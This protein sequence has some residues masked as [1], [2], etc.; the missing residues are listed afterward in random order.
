MARQCDASRVG[1]SELAL[2]GRLAGGK[3]A[4]GG[5][6]EAGLGEARETRFGWEKVWGWDNNWQACE[7]L[8]LL[9]RYSSVRCLPSRLSSSRV[10]AFT[11]FVSPAFLR[12]PSEGRDP[13]VVSLVAVG[14]RSHCRSGAGR[15]SSHRFWIHE[16]GLWSAQ[17]APA[18]VPGSLA[19]LGDGDDPARSVWAARFLGAV[20]TVVL[21]GQGML[22]R[23]RGKKIGKNDPA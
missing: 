22:E 4:L 16:R 18:R 20:G 12:R 1:C 14:W 6:G 11:N 15:R 7:S 2:S 9:M 17:R 3:R 19:C 10:S 13:I 23:G 8:Q 21:G 5:E